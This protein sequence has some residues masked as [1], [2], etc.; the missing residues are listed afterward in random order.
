MNEIV[1]VILFC[2]K[3]HSGLVLG[4]GLTLVRFFT[5]GPYTGNFT[6]KWNLDFWHHLSVY[7]F[8]HKLTDAIHPP[9]V[10]LFLDHP[11]VPPFS[12][13]TAHQVKSRSPISCFSILPFHIGIVSE[14]SQ[15][16]WKSCFIVNRRT[17]DKILPLTFIPS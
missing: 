13:S 10:L 15:S 7:T 6:T 16:S 9:T 12:I 3:V 5:S 1:L 4:K 17:K 2:R 11:D 14:V 8:D